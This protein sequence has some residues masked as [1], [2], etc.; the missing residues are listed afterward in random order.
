MTLLKSLLAPKIGPEI[1]KSETG[2]A[3]AITYLQVSCD[4]FEET[5]S[6]EMKKIE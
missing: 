1:T 2:I 4:K 5:K 6:F 3:D